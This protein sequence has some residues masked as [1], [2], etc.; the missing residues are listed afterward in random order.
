MKSRHEI[1]KLIRIG[2]I[3]TFC[4][5]LFCFGLFKAKNIL[6]GATV[7]LN[8]PLLSTS[9]ASL[10]VLDGIAKNASFLSMNG[11]KIFTDESGYFKEE[12]LLS[13]GYNIIQVEAVDRFGKKETKNL[14]VIYKPS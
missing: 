11:R 3:S 10:L 9:T 5:S 13:T 1:K 2:I 6:T 4:L 8:T 12:L 7:M 14:E